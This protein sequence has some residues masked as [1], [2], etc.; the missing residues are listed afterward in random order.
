[1]TSRTAL[2]A[3]LAM[4]GVGFGGSLPVRAEEN[5]SGTTSESRSEAGSAPA[6]F[7]NR[8]WI[9]EDTGDLPGVVRIFLSDGTLV[10]DS[11]W[12][13]HR[14]SQWK[15]LSGTALSWNE[16]GLDIA[17][18]I[19]SLTDDHLTLRVKLKGGPVDEHYAAAA[20]PAVC[21][22]MPK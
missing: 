22:D 10:E 19:A 17:A 2:F 15:L 11:C 21:P 13:T 9:K 18:D 1:M 8:V 5:P 14:L 20:V 12:E 7:T 16:D 6:G 3:L 4:W